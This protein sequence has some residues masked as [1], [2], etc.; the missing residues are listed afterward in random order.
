MKNEDILLNMLYKF[1]SL[2]KI[3]VDEYTK[4][5]IPFL[6]KIGEKIE[7]YDY[8]YNHVGYAFLQDEKII[9]QVLLE[10]YYLNAVA[11]KEKNDTYEYKYSISST[12]FKDVLK[13][14]YSTKKGQKLDKVLIFNLVDVFKD[15]E[16]IYKCEF[17]TLRNTIKLIDVKNNE[18]AFYRN[19]EFSHKKQDMETKII[20]D[21][22]AF[23]YYVYDKIKDNDIFGY[24]YVNNY[25]YDYTLIEDEFRKII[26]EIDTDYF[27]LLNKQ[28]NI[29]NSFSNGLFESIC[30]KSLKNYN[31]KQLQDML[32]IDFESF[33]KP[34]VKKLK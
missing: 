27:T 15:N 17:D 28:K 25:K 3:T 7:L 12:D 22:G 9:V 14:M 13:G 33:K 21:N 34:F 23:E 5:N 10:N 30:V 26:D 19:N 18:S 8:D 31:K 32:D 20:N 6:L 4:Q 16:L 1:L 24:S 29:I 11:S 2:F